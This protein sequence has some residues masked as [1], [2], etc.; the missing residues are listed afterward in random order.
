MIEVSTSGHVV[1]TISAGTAALKETWK[2][3]IDAELKRLRDKRDHEEALR[4]KETAYVRSLTDHTTTSAKG[5][6]NKMC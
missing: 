3:A 5:Q 6:C 4:K 2:G 1:Q